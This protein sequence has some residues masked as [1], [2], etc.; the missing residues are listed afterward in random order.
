[1]T[2]QLINLDF[3]AMKPLSKFMFPFLLVP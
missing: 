3:Y 1:M 2:K